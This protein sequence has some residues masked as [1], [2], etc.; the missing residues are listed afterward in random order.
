MENNRLINAVIEKAASSY[1]E[2]ITRENGS[3]SRIQCPALDYG[4][5][6]LAI[7]LVN[8]GLVDAD[9]MFSFLDERRYRDNTPD[10]W[11][12]N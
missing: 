4:V 11:W 7:D 6:K 3:I 12:C 2:K 5:R 1:A 9:T 8:E 10:L